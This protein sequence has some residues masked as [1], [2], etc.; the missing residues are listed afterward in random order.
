MK[1]KTQYKILLV[2]DSKLIHDVVMGLLEGMPYEIVSAFDGKEAIRKIGNHEIDLILSDINMPNKGGFE[3]CDDLKAS[4]F[5]DI[6]FVFLTSRDKEEDIVKGLNAG[7]NDY[8]SKPF[9]KE[10]LALRIET[11]IRIANFQKQQSELEKNEHHKAIVTTLNHYLNNSLAIFNT[12]IEKIVVAQKYLPN[13]IAMIEEESRKIA[14]TIKKL[15]D[16]QE[17]TFEYTKYANNTEMLKLDK[18]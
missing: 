9:K 10:E 17:G 3:L 15:S 5:K 16:I 13:E 1:N 14:D 4:R 18:E 6:P 2:D 8:I 7:A 12:A 11:Q